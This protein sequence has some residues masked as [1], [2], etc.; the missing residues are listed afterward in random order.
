M[1]SKVGFASTTPATISN[2]NLTGIEAATDGRNPHTKRVDVSII[3]PYLKQCI[4]V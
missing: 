3:D 1:H 2:K 4:D